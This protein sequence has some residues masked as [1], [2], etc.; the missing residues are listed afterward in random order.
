M[1]PSGARAGGDSPA[2]NRT[3]RPL[4][5]E[6]RGTRPCAIYRPRIV[7]LLL[8][9]ELQVVLSGLIRV[10][11]ASSIW[12]SGA[13]LQMDIWFMEPVV[14]M[15]CQRGFFGEAVLMMELPRRHSTPPGGGG[16]FAPMSERHWHT[17]GLRLVN[18]QCTHIH[19][20]CARSKLHLPV[21]VLGHAPRS[22]TRVT[23]VMGLMA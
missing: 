9:P 13:A 2:S 4:E 17:E 10:A 6:A 16:R 12:P 7:H 8:C 20:A 21:Q 14:Q 19:M 18:W 22:V 5:P 3:S 11:Y 15:S 23:G 1:W